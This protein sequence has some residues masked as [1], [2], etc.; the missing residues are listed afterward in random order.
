MDTKQKILG[1]LD[2]IGHSLRE[3]DGAQALIGLGSVGLELD[4]IDAY[5]DLDFFVIVKTWT[6]Q[7][8]LKDLSWLAVQP[9]VFAFQNTVDGYKALF[10]DGLL[11]E[12]AIFEPQ[13]VSAVHFAQGRLV[14]QAADFEPSILVRT[15]RMQAEP[16]VPWLVGEALTNL[17]VGLGRF[18]RGEKLSATRFIQGYAVDRIVDLTKHIEL[19]Q[20]AN[21]DPFAGERRYELRYPVTA[22]Q[23]SA[24]MQGYDRN[25]QSARAILAFLETHFEVNLAICDAILRL[26]DGP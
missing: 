21:V 1:R 14:W 20:P 4:R 24:F 25:I 2:A 11:C 8:F 15:E 6:K 10:D 26:C 12:F 13:E 16:D 3:T 7:R 18:R 17:F 19:A 23:L 9:I 22:P 5:S